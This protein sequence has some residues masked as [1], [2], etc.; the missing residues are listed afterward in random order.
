MHFSWDPK[1][2][3]GVSQGKLTSRQREQLGKGS[4]RNW[5]LCVYK[6]EII[7]NRRTLEA[8]GGWDVFESWSHWWLDLLGK[9]TGSSQW[10]M[11]RSGQSWGQ[12]SGLSAASPWLSP[13]SIHQTASPARSPISPPGV[14][15]FLQ[16]VELRQQWLYDP[17]SNSCS[18]PPIIPYK[19]TQ[20]ITTLYVIQPW[21]ADC[22]SRPLSH[23]LT[24]LQSHQPSN[25][26]WNMPNIL[27]PLSQNALPQISPE[28]THTASLHSGP[29]ADTT[30]S[31]RLKR[32][33]T[34]GHGTAL[35]SPTSFPTSSS[36][37]GLTATAECTLLDCT[38]DA[39]LHIYFSLTEV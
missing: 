12:R 26:F 38:L 2:R 3:A 23:S 34:P 6:I 35:P 27:R 1:I 31:G 33:V 10:E 30:I 24:V 37:R 13:T 19:E 9:E 36:F 18:G 29:C 20:G 5:A 25:V 22:I 39:V 4:G 14:W 16:A 28:L 21:A 15:Q 17:C 7:K 11:K 32:I 8:W